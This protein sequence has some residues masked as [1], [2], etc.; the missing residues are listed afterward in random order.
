MKKILHEPIPANS[1]C[2]VLDFD[3]TITQKI[4]NGKFVPSLISILYTQ[5]LLDEDYSAR[6][7]LLRDTYY[8]KE[9]DQSLSISE[10][11]PYMEEWWRKHSELLIE[12]KVSL[13]KLQRA[14][15]HEL[16][17]P[18]PG[19]KELFLFASEKSIPVIIFSA[20]GVGE[21]PIRFFLER[22][23]MYAEQ[24][25]IVSNRYEVGSAGE[26]VRQIPPFIHGL[27]KNEDV[28]TFFPEIAHT[29]KSAEYVLLFGDSLHDRDMVEDSHH[30]EVHRV[31]FLSETDKDKESAQLPKFKETYDTV[32]LGES[33]VEE[34][35]NTLKNTC[36]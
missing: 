12:K 2:F 31:G 21:I 19:M 8:P 24:V 26:F 18:R 27:N 30:T 15:Y 29:I 34:I 28:L 5:H 10:K 36:I 35:V 6:A 33:G 20:S 22:F 32:L 25:Y 17:V 7:T 9:I 11:F 14:A 1:T 3:G 16:L 13:E 23:G 4:V